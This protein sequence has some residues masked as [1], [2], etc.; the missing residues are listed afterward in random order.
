MLYL[1]LLRQMAIALYFMAPYGAIA[2]WRH[3]LWRN[4][5][6]ARVT[7]WRHMAPYGAIFVFIAIWRHFLFFPNEKCWIAI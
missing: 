7:K 2:I 6:M 1:Y 5:H 4:R 3:K